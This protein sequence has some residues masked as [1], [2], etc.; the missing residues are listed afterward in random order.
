MADD[1]IPTLCVQSDLID[2]SNKIAYLFSS[3]YQ[4]VTVLRIIFKMQEVH[5][6][7]NSQVSPIRT[8][9]NNQAAKPLHSAFKTDFNYNGNKIKGRHR[10]SLSQYTF[11]QLLEK[12]YSQATD[13]RDIE[14]YL[15]KMHCVEVNHF[16]NITFQAGFDMKRTDRKKTI[17][18]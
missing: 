16:V 12:T 1:S 6:V 5:S 13:A 3:N 14:S 2:K 15:K 17:D 7:W 4:R 8:I 18:N 11:N 9:K 10:F